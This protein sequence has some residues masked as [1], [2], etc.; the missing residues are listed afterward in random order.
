M[1]LAFENGHFDPSILENFM[2]LIPKGDAQSIV[3]DFRKISLCNV[4]TNLLPRCMLVNHLHLFLI[5]LLVSSKEALS[6]DV[7]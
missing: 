7:G 2:V 6:H 5:G 3:K 1:K 4:F